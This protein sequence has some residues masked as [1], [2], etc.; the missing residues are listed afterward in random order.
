MSIEQRKLDHVRYA[1]ELP[2]TYQNG[3]SDLS[4]VHR[5]LPELDLADVSLATTIG[6]LK[7]S[8]PILINAMTGGAERTEEINRKLAEV[9][10][11]TGIAMAVGSQR[12]ALKHDHLVRTYAVVRE[13]NPDG[14]IIA[15]LGAGATVEDARRAVDMIGADLLQ[16]HLNVAQELTMPEGDRSFR[17]IPERIREVV[18]GLDVPVIVKEVGNGM[19]IETFRKLVDIGVRIVDVAGH[20][21]TNFVAIENQRR[22]EQTY[23]HLEGWGQ[24][25]AASLLEAQWYRHQFDLIGSGGIGSATDAAKCFALGARGVGVAGAL[26]RP[27]MEHGVDHTV[28]LIEHWHNEL[29]VILTLQECR[30]ITELC[31][32]PLVVR[33]ETAAWSQLRGIDLEHL[34]R[35]GL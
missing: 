4:F 24:T 13:I 9:A 27:L 28:E 8:S 32:R 15:N 22:G 18:E 2:V 5:A 16:L 26:L 1:L 3:F 17:G 23:R 10:K 21:G 12:A 31:R 19:G 6:G 7:L 34:A 11:R 29:R 33:G 20:G 30:T 14:V 25:T 35:R